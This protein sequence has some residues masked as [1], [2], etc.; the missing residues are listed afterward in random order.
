MCLGP[1]PDVYRDPTSESG[2]VSLRPRRQ[3]FT[4]LSSCLSKSFSLVLSPLVSFW[5]SFCLHRQNDLLF[6]GYTV[7]IFRFDPSCVDGTQPPSYSLL[8]GHSSLLL[9]EV[10]KTSSVSDPH[11]RS[12]LH[13]GPEQRIRSRYPE[14]VKALYQSRRRR[15]VTPTLVS[16]LHSDEPAGG[17]GSIKNPYSGPRPLNS[18]DTE[19]KE[20]T[21]FPSYCHGRSTSTV[22]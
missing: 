1:L 11:L 12:P 4:L 22:S 18:R 3:E 16:E 5:V 2:P 21:C 6:S 15:V 9:L 20:E 17:S 10:P 7:S 14:S 19:T 13:V 8:K